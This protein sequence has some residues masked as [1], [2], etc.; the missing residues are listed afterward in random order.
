MV[1][2]INNMLMQSWHDIIRVFIGTPFDWKDVSFTDL[3]VEG[4][5]EVSATRREGR[6][7][8]VVIHA[9]KP[10]LLCLLNPFGASGCLACV[11]DEIEVVSVNLPGRRWV[12]EAMGIRASVLR[13]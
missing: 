4:S 6:V 2:G 11:R 10:G 9:R 1:E 3:A 5:F 13:S 7:V 8:E 12:A